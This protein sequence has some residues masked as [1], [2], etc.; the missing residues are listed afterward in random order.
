[1]V[2]SYWVGDG[3]VVGRSGLLSPGKVIGTSTLYL[4]VSTFSIGTTFTIPM[5]SHRIVI[6]R[7]NQALANAIISGF[8]S[9]IVN[10]G[11]VIGK[12]AVNGVASIG[13]AFAIRGM[14][15]STMLRVS[16]VNFGALRIPMGNRAA[17][18]VAL[19]RSARGLRRMIII[20]CNSSIGG[21][22]AATI[23]DMDDGSFLTN[24]IGSPV[25][26]ISKGMTKIIIGDIT[27][28]SP[29]ADNDVRI[30]KTSSLG[31]NGD[32][33][34]IVSNVP[35]KSLH[36]LTRS[37]VRSVAMLG[38]NST[39]TVC[40]SHNTGNMVLMAAGRK[41]TNGAA[42]ACSNCIRRSFITDGPSILSTRT[43]LSGIANTISCKRQAG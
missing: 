24:T 5:L 7:R 30:H 40:N 25:R 26:V 22:L 35:K 21:S 12:A 37:S 2:Y 32:P 1:M 16:C 11:I 13:N 3:G 43:C 15:S 20:N 31:T 27:T 4:L 36:G 17:F 41:G 6:V 33:L 39:T 38:S 28:T 8:K 42:V 14:P 9:P 29:G 23:A 34:V 19:R 10:T 18:G